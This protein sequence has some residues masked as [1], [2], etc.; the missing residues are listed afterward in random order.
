MQPWICGRRL[1]DYRLND[2][3]CGVLFPMNTVSNRPVAKKKAPVGVQ[4]GPLRVVPKL[5]A[6]EEAFLSGIT[7][8]GQF[9]VNK[10]LGMYSG[11]RPSRNAKQHGG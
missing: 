9:T 7:T 3:A 2:C 5:S 6:D 8:S 11:V 10:S 4:A 1:N